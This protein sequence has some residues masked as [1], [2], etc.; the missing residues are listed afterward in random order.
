MVARRHR[1]ADRGAE[2]APSART[3]Q[4]P[5]PPRR[6][7]QARSEVEAERSALRAGADAERSR[8]AREAREHQAALAERE[9]QLEGLREELRRQ[10]AAGASDLDARERDVRG[11]EARVAAQRDA[12]ARAQERAEAAAAAAQGGGAAS[13]ASAAAGLR[14]REA[15]LAGAAARLERES[16][17]LAAAR[18][19]VQ[20]SAAPRARLPRPFCPAR[21]GPRAA[22]RSPGPLPVARVGGLAARVPMPADDARPPASRRRSARHPSPRPRD[23]NACPPSLRPLP[24]PTPPR[25]S[26]PARWTSAR[27]PP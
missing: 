21:A 2:L 5:L 14:A 27:P 23:S 25:R 13:A 17:E 19:R 20:A 26:A 10:L 3:S 22:P 12:L 9:R 6:R 15:E 24:F 4:P 1:G 18:D 7:A 11:A 16:A 8:L